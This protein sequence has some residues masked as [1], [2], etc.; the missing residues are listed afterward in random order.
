MEIKKLQPKSL[1]TKLLITFLFVG[2]TPLIIFGVLSIQE[3]QKDLKKEI[4]SKMLLLAEAKEGQLFAYLDLIEGRTDDFSS[5][6]FIGDSLKEISEFQ[7]YQTVNDLNAHLIKNKKTLDE[8]L[9]GIFIMDVNGTIVASTHN[10]EMGKDESADDYFIEGK[11]GVFLTEL[12]GHEH[13]G[14]VKP[15]IVT[16]P[17][18]DKVT[19]EILGVIA[20]IFDSTKVQDSLSGQL[21]FERGLVPVQDLMDL[22]ELLEV[23]IVNEDRV[24]FLHTGPIGSRSKD[25]LHTT[26]VATLPVKRCFED[27]EE[28]V[29]TYVNH[30]GEEVIGASMCIIEK[31]WVLLAEIN[32]ND[33]FAPILNIQFLFVSMI[34]LFAFLIIAAVILFAN[35]IARPIKELHEDIGSMTGGDV[36]ISDIDDKEGDEVAQL[37]NAFDKMATDSVKSQDEVRNYAASLEQKVEERTQELATKV[38]DLEEAKEAMLNI[39]EDVNIKNKQ[40]AEE[41]SKDEAILAS[42][43][44]AL[45]ACDENGK[46]ML[47]N[48]VAEELTGF[49]ATEVIGNHYDKYLKFVSEINETPVVDFIAK[50]IQTGEKTKIEDDALIV[51]K[52]GIKIPVADSAAPIKDGENNIIGCVVVFRDVTREREIDK[53]E[54]DFISTASH[55]LRTPIT[56]IRWVIEHFLKKE[57]VSEKGKEYLEDIHSSTEELSELVD[58]LL[59]VSRIEGGGVEIQAQ[60]I[61]FVELLK[62]YLNEIVP[63]TTKKNLT[64]TF[65][66]H[67]DSLE[68]LT[69]K[70][71]LRNIMQSLVS[72]ALEYTPTG[73]KIDITLKEK[74]DKTF[75]F[76]VTDT[77]IGIPLKAQKTIFDKFTR[78]D[79]AK[80]TN[81]SGTGLGLYIAKKATDLLGGKIWFN[82]VENEGTIFYVELPI[83]S[84]SKT[85]TKKLT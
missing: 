10:E 3:I 18:T 39:A 25:H 62:R 53:M 42:I 63:I 12:A 54:T 20:N 74:D 61:E 23:Y 4:S 29:D 38:V 40:L 37:G 36:A 1:Q 81:T 32:T 80:L 2:L 31:G 7:S 15:F 41:K 84:K 33:A 43:G 50:A 26:T 78:G 55:Q 65:D 75:V 68:I 73:G 14:L 69:D 82:S 51:N 46:I 22:L 70:G 21:Q 85:G 16:A 58:I 30:D 72:N 27:G 64:V 9:S 60:S 19:G 17:I 5:D 34:V 48:A 28:I 79:N 83:K 59:N 76:T 56:G 66:E 44:D 13:F 35:R 67:P 57:K 47:F 71:A 24:M 45:M 49:K 52:T 77:G 11:K 8:L 6:G